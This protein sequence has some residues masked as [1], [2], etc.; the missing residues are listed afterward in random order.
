MDFPF[1]LSSLGH[2]HPQSPVVLLSDSIGRANQS[3]GRD[4]DLPTPNR[5]A[6]L[7]KLKNL[8]MAREKMHGEA[9]QRPEDRLFTARTPILPTKN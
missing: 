2:G 4:G 5:T 6:P 8:A 7:G 1:P 9:G 3:D